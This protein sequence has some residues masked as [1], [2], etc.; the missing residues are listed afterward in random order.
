MLCETVG[1]DS[2]LQNS[3]VGLKCW[4]EPQGNERQ[5]AAYTMAFNL[6]HFRRKGQ[7]DGIWISGSCNATECLITFK[8][9]TLI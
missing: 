4:F 1:V 5:Q 9:E 2:I 8:T 3:T 7:T 6:D